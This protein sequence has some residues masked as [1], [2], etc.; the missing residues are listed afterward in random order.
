[1]VKVTI[2]TN[3]KDLKKGT[4]KATPKKAKKYKIKSWQKLAKTKSKTKKA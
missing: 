2:K 1:M 4:Y 3:G